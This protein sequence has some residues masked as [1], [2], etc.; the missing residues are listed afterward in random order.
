M[1]MSSLSVANS[2]LRVA[3]AGLY[4]IGH[5]M[6]NSNTPGYVRQ[7][8]L[9][10]EFIQKNIGYSANGIL[11]V[12]LG[13]DV[14]RI[15]QIRDK[16]LDIAYRQEV[17]RGSFYQVKATTGLEIETIIGEI[18]SAYSAHAV[19][20]NVWRALNELSVY[21]P[22][23]ETRANFISTCVAFVTKANNVAERLVE[24]QRNLDQQVRDSVT[25][26]N[27]LL[28]QIKNYN[29]MIA[30]AEASG[31][32]ANDF[33]DVRNNAI[34]ELS[35]YLD[36]TYK[37]RPNKQ[38]DIVSENGDLLV[39]NDINY[40]GLKYC[41]GSYNFVEPVF[42]GGVRILTILPYDSP[43]SS[44]RTVFDLTGE[45]SAAINND[46]G[47]LKGLMVA[48]GFEPANYAST[49]VRPGPGTLMTRMPDPTADPA[50]AS[51][52]PQTKA[53]YN[54]YL[55]EF[56]AYEAKYQAYVNGLTDTLPP[57]APRPPASIFADLAFTG[58]NY[59]LTAYPASNY[60]TDYATYSSN[61]DQY[62]K[63]FDI[64]Y[65]AYSQKI[66]DLNY[67][68]I[69]KVLKEFDTIF[70]KIVTLI[71][72]AVSP[73][74]EVEEPVGSGNFVLKKDFANAP[75]G[76]DK[77][78]FD[79]VFIRKYEPYSKRFDANDNYIGENPNEYYSLYTIG[80]VIVNP[81]LLNTDGFNKLA[82]AINEN[83]VE[84]TRLVLNQLMLNWKG[85]FISLSNGAPVSVDDA[86][87]EF[88][89]NISTETSKSIKFCEAQEVLV[90]Q[91]ENKR[92]SVSGV[93][94]DEEMT[95]MLKFHHAYNA[96]ARMI[97]VI[98]SM[99]DK[100]VNETGRA[101]R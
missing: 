83:D 7:R 65:K 49:P 59:V 69:P 88:V 27:Q 17:G 72:D 73:Y 51:T 50:W 28:E 20:D 21:Q 2:G 87:R 77:S 54:K 38:I 37:E 1:S 98:D 61:Y 18:Q 89:N 9:Q 62:K 95:N 6:S 99:I 39:N 52:N 42:T 48:R 82:L 31:D 64:D 75:Y 93:S 66:F 57:K 15:E 60:A 63:Q 91:I 67:A 14:S 11:Q 71:N 22:G 45:V 79:E 90:T 8:V 3:Q 32:R 30:E 56:T 84:D 24:Y 81:E 74:T 29:T 80:N 26:V 76:L 70:N 94:L 12:G 96:S 41:S 23:L 68:V 86:Y 10:H 92:Q 19:I 4:V 44:Y 85:A 53:D 47:A 13:A 101:G 46:K 34:D 97:N 78:Q 55:A 58:S 35:T 5:N 36:I 25:R 100:V 33:R 16:F 43:P 40:M